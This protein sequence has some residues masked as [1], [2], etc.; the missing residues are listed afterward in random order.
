MQEIASNIEDVRNFILNVIND[1][2]VKY[3]ERSVF[4]KEELLPPNGITACE[5]IINDILE[6]KK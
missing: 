3:E 6:S 4:F 2:D 5:N 1:I